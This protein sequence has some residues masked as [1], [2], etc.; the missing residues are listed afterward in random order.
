MNAKINKFEI[1]CWGAFTAVTIM[2]A[3][4]ILNISVPLWVKFL[5][6]GV[7]LG[8]WVLYLALGKE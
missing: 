5:L 3:E 7:V 8:G 1:F 6:A 2:G 4:N